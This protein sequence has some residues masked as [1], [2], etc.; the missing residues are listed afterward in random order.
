MN[1][2]LLL[3]HV[4][5]PREMQLVR[6]GDRARR[7]SAVL[8]NDE[9]GFTAA[10]VVAFER[11]GPVKQDDQ[12]AILLDRARLTQ[13]RKHWFLVGALLRT[14]VQLAHR[15]HRDFELFR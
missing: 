5:K 1:N 11:I 15:H 14:T 12:V 2:R 6:H 4:R 10:R 7:A 8:R 9:V 13:V 3:G